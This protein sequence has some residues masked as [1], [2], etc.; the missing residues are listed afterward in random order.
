MLSAGLAE[1]RSKKKAPQVPEFYHE[2]QVVQGDTLYSIARKFGVSMDRVRK[3]NRKLIGKNDM[4]KV[5]S[6]LKIRASVPMRIKRTAYYIVKK[7]DTLRKIAKR[8]GSTVAELKKVNGLR[9]DLVKPGQK[10]AYL[11]AMP[12]KP[13]ESVG[14]CSS[15]SLV[16]GEKMPPGPGYSYGSRP[17]VYGANE[18]ITLLLEGFGRFRKKH[19]EAPMIVVGNLSRKGGG[20]LDPHKSHQSG[21]DVDLGYMHKAKLQPVTHMLATDESNIDVKLTWALIRTFL[22]TKKVTAI[23]I[24]YRIQGILYE[25]LKKAKV[26]KRELTRLFQYPRGKGTAAV[27]KHVSGHHHHMHIR[28]TC[29]KKD[30]RCED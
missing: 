23:F 5:G 18:T 2:Y 26:S 30:Q 3:W 21:R 15:G 28:F 27:I 14:R 25:Y 19:P 11:V 29:P 1:A 13:S 12:E 22:D 8:T 20:K 9:R 24:D 16:E 10:L 6:V 17:N 4:I 7:G